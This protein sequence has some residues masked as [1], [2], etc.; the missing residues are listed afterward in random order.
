MLNIYISKDTMSLLVF[1]MM[2]KHSNLDDLL[3]QRVNNSNKNYIYKKKEIQ[4]FFCNASV[5]I[6]SNLNGFIRVL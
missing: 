6:R 1:L 5:K 4:S 2:L 3:L